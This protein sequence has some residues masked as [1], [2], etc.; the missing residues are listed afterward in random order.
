MCPRCSQQGEVQTWVNSQWKI[1]AN[2]DQVS[3]EINMLIIDEL[4]HV[5]LSPSGAELLF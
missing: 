4:C 5:P 2:P 3:V 1:S